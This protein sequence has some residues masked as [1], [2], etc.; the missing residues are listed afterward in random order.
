MKDTRASPRLHPVAV[1]RNVPALHFI[2]VFPER[3]GRN[4]ERLQE[5]LNGNDHS[6]EVDVVFPERIVCVDEQVLP[7]CDF[8]D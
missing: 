5:R 7:L 4:P 1:N 8:Q 2:Q 6:F 3:F